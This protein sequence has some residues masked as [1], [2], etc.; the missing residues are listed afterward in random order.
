MMDDRFDRA[1]IF[2]Y[3]HGRLLER[4]LFG[5]AF[6]G[7]DPQAVGRLVAATQNPDGGLGHALEPEIRCPESQPLFVE[8]GLSALREAG[9]RD[10]GLARSMCSFLE[11]VSDEAGLV[12][13]LLKSAFQ[14]PHASHWT[15]LWP[16]GLNPT[17]GICGYLH[18]QGVEHPWLARATRTCC[19]LLL[20]DPPREAHAL[21]SA[22]HLVERL[23]DQPMA[24]ALAERI[25]AALPEAS[26]YIPYAPV[27]T[28]GLT[29]LNFAQSPGSRWRRLFTAEQIEGHL[30]D[31]L[32]RQQADGG[33]P[34][35]WEAPGPASHSEWR[36]KLTLEALK[37]LVAYGNITVT[38]RG[39]TT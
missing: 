26:F 5:V 18:Y 35:T 24:E 30:A 22:A 7:A 14:S 21:A 36:G 28:Y 4:L 31:L 15:T 34:I 2:L 37:V 33:W 27:T 23:P 9:W 3:S 38:R 8:I 12:P 39:N 1:R 32:D 20:Q 29:P 25:A 10:A 13:I 11:G 16:P 19:E 6:E 17:A